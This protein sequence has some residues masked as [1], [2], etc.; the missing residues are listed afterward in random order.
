MMKFAFHTVLSNQTGIV[1]VVVFG[2]L[3][4]S[5]CTG[6]S[7]P[8]A[9]GLELVLTV[10]PNTPP[11][12]SG[13][14]CLGVPITGPG[15]LALDT[16]QLVPAGGGAPTGRCAF[17]PLEAAAFDVLTD[18]R[19]IQGDGF[20]VSLS[21]RAK[22]QSWPSSLQNTPSDP[23][24]EYTVP[25]T[26]TDFC[27]TRLALAPNGDT[28]AVLDDPNGPGSGCAPASR[29]PRVFVW[30]RNAPTVAV[31]PSAPF[32]F[33]AN[34]GPVTIAL[35][36]TR[37]FVLS[38][39]AGEYRLIRYGLDRLTNA[40]PELPEVQPTERINLPLT[41]LGVPNQSSLTVVGQNLI[42][43]FGDG[44][45]GRV[46][47]FP[48]N[49]AQ[50]GNEFAPGNQPIGSVQGVFTDNR[51]NDPNRLPTIA[52]ARLNQNLRFLRG[53][54]IGNANIAAS[55]VTFTPDGFGWVLG[56]SGFLT[57]F[58]LQTLDNLTQGGGLFPNQAL[59]I[60]GLAW[61]INPTP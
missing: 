27:P 54:L 37:L 40:T 36:D 15:V 10:N 6:S 48:Q 47:Q 26:I 31:Q 49:A 50:P 19:T 56:T 8:R 35:S 29:A 33:Q 30:K 24:R 1:L 55:A 11:A 51:S 3:V 53:D 59:R 18:T 14:A 4:L 21:T 23:V 39:Q 16:A 9:A 17:L 52:F 22:L 46:F 12:Q 57:Q 28:V 13:I 45:T 32:P 5:S 38:P 41:G 34:A 25:S 60:G 2:G 61:I 20:L 42:L 7:E 43:S 58:D 44:F